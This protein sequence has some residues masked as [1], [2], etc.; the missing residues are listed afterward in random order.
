[1]NYSL[2]LRVYVPREGTSARAAIAEHSGVVGTPIKGGRVLL[3][4]EANMYGAVN[5][6][7]FADAVHHAAGRH[8]EGYPTRARAEVDGAEVVEVGSYNGDRVDIY[9]EQFRTVAD[10]LG[11]EEERVEAECERS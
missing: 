8:T 6:Q 5:I 3:D 11:V 9:P 10:W 4:F 1:M 2:P 7:T